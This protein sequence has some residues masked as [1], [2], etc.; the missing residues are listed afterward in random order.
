[1]LT[2]LHGKIMTYDGENRPVSVSYLGDT[3]SYSYGPDGK[4]LIK[5]VTS[6]GQTL[7]TGAVE[8]RDYGR[9]KRG[10]LVRRLIGGDHPS[11]G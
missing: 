7:F 9:A 4:R 8:V 11:S 6:S 10:F 1:M 2:C 5:D 3:T